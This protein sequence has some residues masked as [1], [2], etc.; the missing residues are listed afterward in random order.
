MCGSAEAGIWHL[1]CLPGVL[2][3]GLLGN[4]GPLLASAE[5][6]TVQGDGITKRDWGV[7]PK[8][9]APLP[10]GPFPGS[11][12]PLQA[13]FVPLGPTLTSLSGRPFVWLQDLVWGLGSSL[14]VPQRVQRIVPEGGTAASAE[15]RRASSCWM[16][17]PSPTRSWGGPSPQPG[18][19][20]PTPSAEPLPELPPSPGCEQSGA[21]S[22]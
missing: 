15:G 17:L 8:P 2:L 13:G 19:R 9:T 1:G 20:L 11:Q 22:D 12:R 3:L 18:S 5:W 21:L 7:F 14:L 6:A 16:E 4:L 10:R